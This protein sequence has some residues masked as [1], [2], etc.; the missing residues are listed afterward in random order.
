[1][2]TPRLPFQKGRDIPDEF[3]K[4]SVLTHVLLQLQSVSTPRMR[5]IWAENMQPLAQYDYRTVSRSC[6]NL[7]SIFHDT[8]TVAFS[9]PTCCM[10]AVA[11]LSDNLQIG[12]A[13]QGLFGSRGCLVGIPNHTKV[14]TEHSFPYSQAG[15]RA[16]FRTTQY[17]SKRH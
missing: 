2:S 4:G 7:D 9:D 1:M 6:H 5:K 11:K 13:M 8:K 14:F 15:Y 3:E 16:L 12:C 10:K 17:G